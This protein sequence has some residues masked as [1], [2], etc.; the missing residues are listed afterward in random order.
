MDFF[1]KL[2]KK[3]SETYQATKEKA[4]N[5]SDELKL[6][7]KISEQKEKI[8]KLY[9]EIGETV[10]NEIKDGKDVSREAIVEKSDE[11]SKAKDEI[12]KLEADILAV[13]K[14]KKCANC[15]TELDINAEFC[16]KCGKE[17]P[18]IE[19]VEIK[20]EPVQAE[21]AE[22]VEVSDVKEENSENSEENSNE[23]NN[24]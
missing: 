17:Q 8:E 3:A 24:Q 1:N 9:R 4:T 15:G 16:S 21:N 7:G 2:G 11:I 10:Y 19:K 18:K 23:N 5:I 6:K 20:K 14:I 13:K 12:S 22:V